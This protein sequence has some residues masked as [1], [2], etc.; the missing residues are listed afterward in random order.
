MSKI[1]W[2]DLTFNP[3]LGCNSKECDYCYARGI[4]KRFASEIARKEL[5]AKYIHVANHKNKRDEYNK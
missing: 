1:E 4:D 5:D 3:V 2:T